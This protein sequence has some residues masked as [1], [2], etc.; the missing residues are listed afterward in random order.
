[1]A[2][3]GL[4]F[5]LHAERDHAERA[6]SQA[7]ERSGLERANAVILFLSGE[8]AANPTPAVR[9][10]ARAA[11]CTQVVGC[12]GSGLLTDQEWVLDSPGAAAMVLGGG[13]R[14]QPG[15]PDEGG[16]V[17][18][19]CTP[20]GI[21]AEWLAAPVARIGAVSTDL[22]GQGPFAVWGGGRVSD[23]GRTEARFTG[24]RDVLRTAQGIRALTAPIEV[25]A[26]EG[27]ELLRLGN[28]PALNVLVQSLPRGVQELERVPFHLLISG[29][30]FG[31]PDTAI[32]DGRFRL[33][34]I[35]AADPENRSITLA[36]A[37]NPGERLFWAIRD[38]LSAE[39]AF[40]TTAEQAHEA[41]Q[42]D[43]DF[44]LLFPCVAR[45]PSFFGNRDRDIEVMRQIFPG[46]PF[47]GFYGNGEIGPL[48]GE[49][50]LHQYSTVLGLYHALQ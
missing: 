34:H 1:M 16:S 45:G 8:Y 27:F 25:A 49:N 46:L 11:G 32:R 12:T 38:A 2:A 50:H 13:A 20:Y 37:L 35:M 31:D 10:A 24:V 17:L 6:V 47:I 7:M 41:L 9:A 19:L 15:L 29:V 33:N 14:L 21:D 36:Q 40:R 28:Y 26:V 44:A 3:T 43:P 22:L 5:G 18:S 23:H 39:Q 30:T 48:N 42:A 4:S